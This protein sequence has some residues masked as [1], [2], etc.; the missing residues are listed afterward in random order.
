MFTLIIGSKNYSSWSMRPWVLLRHF[1][2][3]FAERKL[4]LDSPEF[5]AALAPITPT[6]TVPVLL[7]GD[8]V[9]PDTL[10]IVE[11]LAERFPQH[12]IWPAD[13]AQRACARVLCAAMHAGFQSLRQQMPMNIEAECPG[14]G[15]NLAVQRDIDRICALWDGAL[16]ASGGPFLFGAFGAADAFYA[17]VC[18]RFRTYA[19]K[20]PD[21]A[22]AYAR[23]VLDVPAVRQW[24]DEGRAEHDFIPADE[25]YRSR[26]DW[27]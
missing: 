12:A 9:V 20:L 5:Y 14:L 8:L 18:A 17:P 21:F 23:R 26:P 3:A 25:P 19:P 1:G 11:C 7:D 13:A 16:R 15:W 22:A 10:A 6:Q 2:I 4:R 24:C 27:S